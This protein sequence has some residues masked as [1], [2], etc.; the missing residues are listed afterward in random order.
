[1]EYDLSANIADAAVVAADEEEM[2]SYQSVIN[3][4]FLRAFCVCLILY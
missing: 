4:S 1:M 3:F 2:F